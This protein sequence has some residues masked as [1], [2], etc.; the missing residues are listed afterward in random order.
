MLSGIYMVTLVYYYEPPEG[1]DLVSLIP[2][3]TFFGWLSLLALIMAA[4]RAF[5][6]VT[7]PLIAQF[8]DQS[9][10]PNGR[11]IPI[12]RWTF[13]PTAVFSGLMYLPWIE[14]AEIANV[15]WLGFTQFGF[16]LCMTLYNVPY[17][18]LLPELGHTSKEKL[19]LATMQGVM[20]I[21]GLVLAAAY[22][23]LAD[24]LESVLNLEKRI[25]AIQ[26]SIWIY[27]GV[28]AISLAIPA[29]AISE[30]KYCVSKPN[31]MNF[32]KA[33]RDTFSNR[34]F[35]FFLVADFSYFTAMSI[36]YASLLYYVTVLLGQEE[37]FGSIIVGIMI[38]GSLI[39]LIPIGGQSLLSR[40]TGRF[41]KKRLIMFSFFA[42]TVMMGVVT[43]LG[44]YPIDEKIQG[45]ILGI[46]TCLPLAIMS[47]LPTTLLAEISD[48]DSKQTG[49]QKEGMYFGVRNFLQKVGQMFGMVAI[50][51]LIKLGKDPGDD[52]GIRLTAVVGIALC[53][54]AA[55]IF[56]F[57]NETRLN[58]AI[59]E[60]EDRHLPEF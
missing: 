43:G 60:V 10:N 26:Y 47:I 21:L 4:G 58:R 54:A 7:D 48:L 51:L 57:F 33:L 46:G 56:F 32:R 9:K 30:K 50:A 52:L 29:F 22:L 1:Q 24:V 39:Y 3:M 38:A 36:I 45:Y 20:L 40:L 55:C 8:T 49:Q 12:M 31:S 6:A 11:R 23:Q 28:S 2:D 18:A 13:L 17:N 35:K 5:D 27:C 34:H 16:F 59:D 44:M 42:L 41:G 14:G 15:Y 19:E 53:I 25:R 37:S